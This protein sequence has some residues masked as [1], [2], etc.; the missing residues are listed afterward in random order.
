MAARL[1]GR[2]TRRQGIETRQFP[3]G[4]Q[5]I[6]DTRMIAGSWFAYL[7]PSF[8]GSEGMRTMGRLS[9]GGLFALGL[10]GVGRAR[11]AIIG[12]IF[13]NAHDG[14]IFFTKQNAIFTRQYGEL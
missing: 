2:V 6:N 5:S 13:L 4:G 9:E 11:V 12:G 8:R 14:V 3:L 10:G 7:M 1:R